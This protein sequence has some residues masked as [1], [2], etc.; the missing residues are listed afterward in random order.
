M[1]IGFERPKRVPLYV[2][3]GATVVVS[4]FGIIAGVGTAFLMSALASGGVDILSNVSLICGKPWLSLAVSCGVGFITML[5]Q[6]RILRD[7]VDFYARF[8]LM[9]AVRRLRWPVV[10]VNMPASLPT[11]LGPFVSL[12]VAWVLRIALLPAF[13][14][15]CIMSIVL[16]P[17]YA[18]IYEEA[19]RLLAE[20]EL[21]S[22]QRMQPTA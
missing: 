20:Q 8:Y 16:Y 22:N 15:T 18:R 14:G 1:E 6:A 7:K 12:A 3:P 13:F 9:P 4:A 2:H 19:K 21:S 11:L 5:V 17:V 10:K